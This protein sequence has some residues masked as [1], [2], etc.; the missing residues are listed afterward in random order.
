MNITHQTLPSPAGPWGSPC[1]LDSRTVSR[2]GGRDEVAMEKK[3]PECLGHESLSG[4]IWKT[5]YC[6]GSCRSEWPAYPQEPAPGSPEAVRLA[7]LEVLRAKA[8][9]E[10]RQLRE[11]G[12]D[13][14]G[15]L[16]NRFLETI[17]TDVLEDS[18]LQHLIQLARDCREFGIPAPKLAVA[19]AAETIESPVPVTRAIL[20]AALPPLATA[21]LCELASAIVQQRAELADALEAYLENWERDAQITFNDGEDH[22]FATVCRQGPQDNVPTTFYVSRDRWERRE[23]AREAL[24]KA[25]RS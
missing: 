17:G 19:Q 6:D 11:F 16:V 1:D 25:G 7:A 20:V 10:V 14:A 21:D 22:Y 12:G 3:T 18:T 13:A 2:A 23:K 8:W 5:T 4:P 9:E 24:A 15:R